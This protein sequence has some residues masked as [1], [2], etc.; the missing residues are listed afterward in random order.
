MHFDTIDARDEYI[1]ERHGEH[2]PLRKI[3]QQVGLSHE[4]VRKIIKGAFAK[5]RK[6]DIIDRI[7]AEGEEIAR[8]IMLHCRANALN[9]R[10]SLTARNNSWSEYRLAW[11]SLRRLYGVDEPVRREA[12]VDTSGWEYQMRQEIAMMELENER[13]AREANES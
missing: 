11:E 1:L 9:E 10:H 2:Q 7:Q 13:L 8:D 5:S 3:A 4:G 12:V 6:A